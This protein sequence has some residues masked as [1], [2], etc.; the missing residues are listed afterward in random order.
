[1]FRNNLSFPLLFCLLLIS[2]CSSQSDQD[3]SF[4]QGENPQEQ[5][6]NKHLREW[7]KLEPELHELIQM[8]N[9]IKRLIAEVDMLAEETK[10]SNETREKLQ[11]ITENQ[12]VH[13]EKNQIPTIVNK[14][15]FSNVVKVP[16]SKSHPKVIEAS[17]QFSVQLGSFNSE[18]LVKKTWS[19][20]KL[21]FPELLN[22][23]KAFTESVKTSNG[24]TLF[25]LKVGPYNTKDLAIQ[26]CTQLSNQKQNCFVNELS[27]HSIE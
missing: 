13:K 26:T 14:N 24:K 17:K 2:G 8:K 5:T 10:K 22:S 3:F 1:M 20:A 18:I 9:D 27:G 15:T 4:A 6:L 23:K 7:Q 19:E 12:L 11:K 21:K 16:P 25:R